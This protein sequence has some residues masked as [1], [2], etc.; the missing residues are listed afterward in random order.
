MIPAG[1]TSVMAGRRS[2]PKGLDFFPTPPWATR[3]FMRHILP[4]LS[5]EP[6]R[7]VWD[8]AC[9]EGHMVE[10]LREGM[11]D[12]FASDVFDYGR[13]YRVADFLAPDAGAPTVDAIVTNP[14]FN[15]AVD[16][17]LRA[18]DLAPVVALLCRT[19]WLEGVGR[20]ERL[21]KLRPVT[22]FAPYV[23]RV[24][25]HRGQWKPNGATATAYAFFCWSDRPLVS[26]LAP[27]PPGQRKLLTRRD[28]VARFAAAA[29]P[30]LLAA[31]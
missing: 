9:G 10:V 1:H 27:I 24:P 26:G 5:D 19:S 20:Y 21:F 2:P 15:A 23:E 29:A 12:T 6:I 30:S 3:A 13:G 14:P 31:E 28:D 7:S 22:V 25:M 17:A 4:L 18:L 8:P 11:F 16:F